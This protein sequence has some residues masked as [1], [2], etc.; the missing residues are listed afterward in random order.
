MAKPKSVYT[1]QGC[2]YQAPSWLG[3]CPGCGQWN[4]LAEE[5]ITEALVQK[6]GLQ[7][8]GAPCPLPE[9][10]L[11]NCRRISSQIE[12]F[13]RVLGGGTVP[14]SLV[15]IGGDPGIGKSTLLLQTCNGLALQGVR[16]LYIS[17]EESPQQIK[18]R[19]QRLNICT[20]NLYILAE[21]ALESMLAH[22]DAFR[23]VILVVDSIQT[24][25]STQMQSAPGS[26]SQVREVTAQLL[27]YSK[28]HHVATFIVGHVTKDGAIAGP[29][30]LEHIVDTVLYLEGD[31][32]QSYRILRA[33]K[34]RF[35]STNE[36]GVFEMVEGGLAEIKN[37]SQLFLAERSEG[38]SG[39]VA[40]AS[41]EGT[42]P[43]LLEV[44]ALVS[45]TKM[46]M[47]RRST[48]GVDSNRL[49]L[50]TAVMEKRLG[51]YLQGEDI[52]INIV[53]GMKVD[54]PAADLGIS[55]AII[56]SFRNHPLDH[57]WIVMGEIGLGGEIRGVSSLET[58]LK[59]ASKLGF[60]RA[61]VPRGNLEK[62][63][64]NLPMEIHGV[65]LLS[66]A[67]ELLAG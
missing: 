44:Q 58:R 9:I 37:P 40:I 23:P 66:E 65:H 45:P 51:I 18:L 11:Q 55:C 36:I 42:R 7:T 34:N 48:T 30:T 21:T 29:R 35:G 64:V 27:F 19:A 49:S 39:A 1:C 10:T 47:P 14:G 26:V 33:V 4:T 5:M 13:D 2:G 57:D 3:R 43:I 50:I 60:K 56:S 24:S 25:Y 52:F 62:L 46:A 17:G 54:E 20:P 8:G 32:Y 41:L 16:V 63:K 31:R 12:E 67:I 28:L 59:E 22:L 15:L 61:V 53:S 38:I 6:R